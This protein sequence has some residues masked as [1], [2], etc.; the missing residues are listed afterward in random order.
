MVLKKETIN[1]FGIILMI[2]NI[3]FSV[4]RFNLLINFS[5]FTIGMLIC[6][7]TV[8]IKFIK[9]KSLLPLIVV[10]LIFLF[11]GFR[12]MSRN[13]FDYCAK[14]F[15][16]VL[17]SLAILNSPI[18]N[19]MK[20]LKLIKKITLLFMIC[21][22]LSLI[23]PTIYQ[24]II[25]AMFDTNLSNSIMSLYDFGGYAGIA[26]QTGNNAFFLSIGLAIILIDIIYPLKGKKTTSNILKLLL[27]LVAII[28]T[29]KRFF[30]A[31]I[32]VLICFTLFLF[33]KNNKL[34]KKI[35]LLSIFGLLV[36]VFGCIFIYNTFPVFDRLV[37]SN[38][39]LNG[40]GTLYAIAIDLIKNNPFFGIGI[41]NYVN[42]SNIYGII[43]YAHNVFLQLTAEIGIP[44]SILVFSIL[45]SYLINVYKNYR[46]EKI[47]Q[48][49]KIY[50]FSFF[51]QTVFLLYFFTGNS[52]YDTNMLMFYF[53]CIGLGCKKKFLRGSN[54]EK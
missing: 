36:A 47:V 19:H 31:V 23:F 9:L 52:L 30:L 4:V 24:I 13:S 20:A 14:F 1:I 12:Y 42:Y 10:L 37:N 8:N 54:N 2:I 44:F 29:N 28:L 18:T 49:K 39:V 40:R 41:N 45:F 53:L 27:F 17:S 35:I 25:K 50:L 16:G 11:S 38:D 7:L 5:I 34:T 48:I 15:I 3:F 46:N 22:F 43:Y 33:Y 26:G 21:T 51:S 6:L 32:V